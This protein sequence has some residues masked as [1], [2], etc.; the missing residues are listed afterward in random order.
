[1]AIEKKEV[2]VTSDKMSHDTK[3]EAVHHEN[4]IELRKYLYNLDTDI[5]VSKPNWEGFNETLYK[6]L[7]SIGDL[8]KELLTSQRVVDTMNKMKWNKH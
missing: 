4:K 2:Y 8:A 7:V 5:I 1:M 3:T 6:Q